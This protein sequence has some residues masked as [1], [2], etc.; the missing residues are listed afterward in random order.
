MKQEEVE[1]LVGDQAALDELSK[2]ASS[3]QDRA[4]LQGEQARL[5]EARKGLGKDAVELVETPSGVATKAEVEAW[6]DQGHDIAI[7]PYKGNRR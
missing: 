7:G 5:D 1:Q 6:R 4:Y 2:E 3:E